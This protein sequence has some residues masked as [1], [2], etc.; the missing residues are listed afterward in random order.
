MTELVITRGYPGSG[1][2]T[3]ARL[4]LNQGPKRARVSR[5]DYRRMLFDGE[6]ILS[7]DEENQVTAVQ[8]AA[9]ARLL[10]NGYDVI[11]D[12]TNLRRRYA[13]GWAD[14]AQ[15]N[16]ATFRVMDIETPVQMCIQNNQYRATWG[17]GRFVDP[18]AII[19]LGQKFPLGT[20]PEIEAS[21]ATEFEP[22]APQLTKPRAIIWDIDGTLAHMTGRS[23][24]DY[25][26]V[27]ED[28]VDESVRHLANMLYP[29]HRNIVVSG[30][31][32]DCRPETVRWLE[33]KT[34]SYDDLYMR[35]AG[36]SRDDAIV[37]YEIFRDLIAPHY[38]VIGVFDDRDRVVDM[39]RR[40]GLKCFQVQPGDF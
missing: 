11:E 17:S 34:V 26:R 4:W 15:C 28:D 3:F 22:Y 7:F 19:T 33:D 13:R 20:W 24:Y 30:R 14:F 8:R 35:Q 2:T 32:E 6:G 23:P 29:D 10:A 25:T 5:D 39:W 27:S 40:I 18:E 37:K 36:D 1:K 21:P 12:G 16:G 31:S 9:V 38:N